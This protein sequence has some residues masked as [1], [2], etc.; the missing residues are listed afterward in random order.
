MSRK[1]AGL[2]TG[3]ALVVAAAAWLA[4]SGP[5]ALAQDK[6]A[7]GWKDVTGKVGSAASLAVAPDGSQI[8]AGAMRNGFYGST[9]GGATWEKLGAGDKEQI[10]SL[11]TDVLFDPKDPKTFWVSGAYK[12]SIFKTSDAGKSFQAQGALWHMD[13]IAVD[14]SDPARKT[15]LTGMHETPGKM[16]RSTDG[17]V[18]WWNISKVQPG[19]DGFP[20][21][22][23]VCSPAILD[24]KTY[25]IGCDPSWLA[26]QGFKPGIALT[27]D[28]GETWTTVSNYGPSGHPLVAADGAI[29]W[30]AGN[31]LLKS[32]DKGKTWAAINAVTATPVELAAGKLLSAKGNQ[33][34]SSAD[35]GKTWEKYGDLCP[36]PIGEI[37]YDAKNKVIYVLAK[38][39]IYKLGAI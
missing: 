2:L 3:G 29:Y 14:F 30:R 37:N 19:M 36:N 4:L 11:C 9:D 5:L 26:S 39:K 31:A 18:K 8:V 6:G 17:G 27:T 13:N 25:I 34:Y 28:G 21:T 24:S 20:K 1:I 10:I 16:Y 22:L 7:A 12:H 38:A 23:G 35:A 33:L 32:A 15:L